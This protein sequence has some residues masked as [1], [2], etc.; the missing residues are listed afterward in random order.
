MSEIRFG[1]LDGSTKY[2]FLTVKSSG[3][4]IETI[5]WPVKWIWYKGRVS[6]LGNLA[7]KNAAFRLTKAALNDS[8]TFYCV[9]EWSGNIGEDS[10]QT[11]ILI[12]GLWITFAVTF[13]TFCRMCR[14]K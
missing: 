4:I 13:W 2:K 11:T 10:A 8:R 7:T 6:W 12:T 9:V 1:L 5:D 14:S 3:A